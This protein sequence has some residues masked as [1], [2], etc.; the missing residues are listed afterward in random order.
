MRQSA[1]SSYIIQTVFPAPKD[2]STIWKTL[3]SFKN[4]IMSSHLRR[5]KSK[6]LRSWISE[7]PPNHLPVLIGSVVVIE[8]KANSEDVLFGPMGHHSLQRVSVFNC[9]VC[10]LNEEFPLE[11]GGS[12]FSLDV[13]FK[14]DGVEIKDDSVLGERLVSADC[15]YA[16][17]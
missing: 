17:K 16:S 12:C 11:H 3:Q 9:V 14:Q 6:L 1:E 7:D 13:V 2:I 10:A 8:L 5:E 4:R 15:R